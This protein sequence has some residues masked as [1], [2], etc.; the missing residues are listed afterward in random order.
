MKKEILNEVNRTREIMGLK[1]LLVEKWNLNRKNTWTDFLQTYKSDL[2]DNVEIIRPDLGSGSNYKYSFSDWAYKNLLKAMKKKYGKDFIYRLDGSDGNWKEMAWLLRPDVLASDDGLTEDVVMLPVTKKQIKRL[3]DYHMGLKPGDLV[4]NVDGKLRTPAL[5]CKDINEF[6]VANFGT[7]QIASWKYNAGDKETETIREGETDYLYQ[8]SASR[9]KKS[10]KEVVT[11]GSEGEV[12]A[13]GTP[14]PGGSAF[15]PNE[16]IPDDTKIQEL[17]AAI[18]ASA[19]EGNTVTNVKIN[20]VASKTVIDKIQ[21]WKD[22][23]GEPYNTMSDANI[24]KLVTGPFTEDNI[25]TGNQVLAYL[26]A[27]NLGKALEE[28][29]ITVD[30]YSYSVGGD[31]MKADVIITTQTPEK[32]ATPGTK[33]TEFQVDT[34]DLSLNSQVLG[35]IISVPAG[36]P[37][38]KHDSWDK[39]T[40]KNKAKDVIQSNNAKG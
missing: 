30:S 24:T 12:A 37:T 39:K 19:A 27:Q 21:T 35:M 3:G 2:F 6:N 17:L 7:T 14:I 31:E 32:K 4:I 26:R 38:Y 29:D 5:F 28:A 16:V 18:Q 22:N 34:E 10:S 13:E 25:T 36:N 33:T 1:E 11:P 40:A 9:T 23:V 15:A 20:G 8:F